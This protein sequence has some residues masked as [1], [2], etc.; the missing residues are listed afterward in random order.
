MAELFGFTIQRNKESGAK[1]VVPPTPDDGSIDVAGGGFFGQ[2]LD[3]DGR[4]RSDLELIRRYRDIS[5]QPEC[6]TAVED[7]V[8]EGIVSNEDDMPIQIVLEQLPYTDKIKR[9][10]RNE[11][12]EV[13]RL[14]NFDIKGHDIFRRWYV[15]GRIYYH[16]I[17]DPKDTRKG[18]TELRYVDATKIKKV[19]E[20]EKKKD[21]KTGVDI[22]F[23]YLFNEFYT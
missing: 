18:I 13:L 8:N 3:T 15:D 19:R 16:K 21:S 4:E 14:L 9:K 6:D 7:I 1:S 11:F 5:Q 12:A 23:F 17:I 22:I 2:I 20:V 10:I